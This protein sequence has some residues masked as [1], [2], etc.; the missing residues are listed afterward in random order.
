MILPVSST[1]MAFCETKTPEHHWFLQN[2]LLGKLKITTWWQDKMVWFHD[3]NWWIVATSHAK[4]GINL[5]WSS[6]AQFVRYMH[7]V[8]LAKCSGSL[9]FLTSSIIQYSRTQ[10][11]TPFQKLDVFP[12]SGEGCETPNLLGPLERAYLNHCPVSPTP[13]LRMETDPVSE[14]FVFFCVF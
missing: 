12:S 10:K 1:S 6:F 14:T 9:G 7:P 4:F 2:V 3:S 11:N 13:H 8:Q 5:Y